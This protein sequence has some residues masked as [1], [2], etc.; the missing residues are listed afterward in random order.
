MSVFI[1]REP[2]SCFERKYKKATCVHCTYIQVL[3]KE[4]GF[5]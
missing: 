5:P 3:N 4:Y 1:Q 2:Y